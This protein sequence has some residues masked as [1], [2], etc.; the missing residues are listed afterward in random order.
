MRQPYS[1]L[2]VEADA[3]QIHFG[4]SAK[5][6]LNAV[7]LLLHY[8]ILGL[9]PQFVKAN[10]KLIAQMLRLYQLDVNAHHV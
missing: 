2:I 10:E 4:F 3:P 1:V 6:M 8:C 7:G 5:E 9:Q